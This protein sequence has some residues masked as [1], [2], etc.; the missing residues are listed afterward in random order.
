[1][2]LLS[3]R[4]YVF[5]LTLSYLNFLTLKKHL[6]YNKNNEY[7]KIWRVFTLVECEC[8]Y[9]TYVFIRMISNDTKHTRMRMRVWHVWIILW[10]RMIW[11]IRECE[12]ECA[13]MVYTC[14]HHHHHQSKKGRKTAGKQHDRRSF[15]VFGYGDGPPVPTTNLAASLPY[16]HLHLHLLH[17]LLFPFLFMGLP[18]FL[19]CIPQKEPLSFP[20]PLFPC[21][22]ASED[23]SV[24]A[25]AVQVFFHFGFF[26][27]PRTISLINSFFE[28][29]ISLFIFFYLAERD[30]SRNLASFAVHESF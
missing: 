18:L 24:L 3:K 13:R 7:K 22:T 9:G 6:P 29:S 28:R 4:S 15:S 10:S 17:L 20:S 30:I 8:A 21:P 12:C 27:L 1:M 14:H 26:W 2:H 16:L 11:N 23:F 25:P 5:F 19:L